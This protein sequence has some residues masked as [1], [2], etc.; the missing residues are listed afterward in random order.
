[1]QLCINEKCGKNDF[2]IDQAH[3]LLLIVLDKVAPNFKK[4]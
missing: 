3:G 1:M 2:S 4:K